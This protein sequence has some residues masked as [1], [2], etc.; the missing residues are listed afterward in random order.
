MG[1]R[2]PAIFWYPLS[3][4]ATLGLLGRIEEGEKFARKLFEL[5]PDFPAK[6]RAL[7][8]HYIKFEKIAE[9]VIEG[10]NKVGIEIN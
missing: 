3:K 10:L 9:R 5:R 6:G 1:L 7:I 8:G 4:A 2:L